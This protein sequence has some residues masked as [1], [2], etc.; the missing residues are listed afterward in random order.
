MSLARHCGLLLILCSSLGAQPVTADDFLQRARGHFERRRFLNALDSLRITLQMTD[1]AENPGPERLEAEVLAAESLAALQRHD[2]AVNMYERALSHGYENSASYAYLAKQY[3][4][5]G[6]WREA[7]RH[8]EKYF[9]MNKSD[10]A[11]HIRYAIVLGRQGD[12]AKAKQV[13]EAIEPAVA[14][15]PLTECEALE[16]K[17]KTAAALECFGDARFARPDREA[18]YLALYR[19]SSQHRQQTSAAEHAMAL[20]AL[21]GS[22]ARYIWPLVEVRLQQKR[23]YAARLLL[24]EIMQVAGPNADAERLLTNLQRQAPQAFERPYRASPKEMQMLDGE[25]LR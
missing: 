14:A 8:Y 25:S 10:S 13:L 18:S 2:E 11:T 24:E 9:E 16:K 19:I 6:K 7:K 12:R 21:F 5:R 4:A 15:K 22:E 23:F 1:G 3:D 20:Y 17:K